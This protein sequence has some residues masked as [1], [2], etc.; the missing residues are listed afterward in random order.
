MTRE[1]GLSDTQGILTRPGLRPARTSEGLGWG[2]LY[3]STQR[4]LPYRDV[5]DG[6]PCHLTILHLDGPV[7]VRRGRRGLVSTERVPAGG[8]VPAPRRDHA[9]RRAGRIAEHRACLPDR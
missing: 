6:A 5:F 3:L 8:T 7:T 4:E 9:Q 2:S 1:L